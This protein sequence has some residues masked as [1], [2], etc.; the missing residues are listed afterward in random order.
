MTAGDLLAFLNALGP[1]YDK[2]RFIY[3]PVPGLV[4]FL[5]NWNTQDVSPQGFIWFFYGHVI[6]TDTYLPV[7]GLRTYL[8]ILPPEDLSLV[9][10]VGGAAGLE[11]VSGFTTYP[12][13]PD[14]SGPYVAFLGRFSTPLPPRPP[15]IPA[16]RRRQRGNP[17]WFPIVQPA[18]P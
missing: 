13:Q 10:W 12:V 18:D 17:G 3:S 9:L 15:P 5:D 11:P 6:P 7:E 8:S 1:E 16:D 2:A 14:G 4:L